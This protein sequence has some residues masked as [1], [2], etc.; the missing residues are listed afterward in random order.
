MEHTEA[1]VNHRGEIKGTLTAM[2]HEIHIFYT[3]FSAACDHRHLGI[4]KYLVETARVYVNLAER[5]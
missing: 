5:G 1:D 2:K 3:P 4:V